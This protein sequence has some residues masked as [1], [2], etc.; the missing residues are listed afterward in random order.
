MDRTSNYWA[1][2]SPRLLLAIVS[3]LHVSEG[4]LALGCQSGKRVRLVRKPGFDTLGTL[5]RTETGCPGTRLTS[6]EPLVLRK[7]ESL[8]RDVTPDFAC[9]PIKI[10]RSKVRCHLL[11]ALRPV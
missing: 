6:F 11:G 7:V 8:V 10:A 2:S 9:V 4:C 1:P 5:H 3:G